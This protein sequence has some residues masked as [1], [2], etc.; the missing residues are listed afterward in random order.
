MK[1]EQ[2]SILTPNQK[3]KVPKKKLV[4]VESK[5]K[6]EPKSNKP[7]LPDDTKISL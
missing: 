5:D 4:G 6:Q 7:R 3:I 2:S 1:K